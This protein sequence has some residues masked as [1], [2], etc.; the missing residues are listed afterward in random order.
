MSSVDVIIPCY[1]YGHFLT[2]CVESV[3]TQTSVRVQVLIIDDASPDNSAEVAEDLHRRFSNVAFVRHA[4]N[5]GHIATYNEGI[6][7]ASGDYLMI[8]SADDYLLPG[9]LRYSV[10]LMDTHAEVGMTYGRAITLGDNKAGV[11][12]KID[13]GRPVWRVVSGAKFMRLSGA[14]NI[15]PTPTAVVRTSLQ[16]EVGG[17][18]PELP[19]SGDMELWLRLAARS[20]I[21][22]IDVYQ[23]VYR[24]H[25]SN[26]SLAY[27]Q[28]GWLPD[29]EQ[30]Q[31]ALQSF[32]RCCGALPHV[33]SLRTDMIRS[34]ALEALSLASSAFNTG[35]TDIAERI[36]RFATST[37][38]RVRCSITWGKLRCK[39]WMGYQAW[40][41]LQ[42]IISGLPD[43]HRTAQ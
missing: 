14:R 15:V 9:A 37:D 16:K 23:A 39:Q 20:S 38:P 33:R 34:L 1:R 26:M 7:W 32:F 35:E 22:I 3:L 31:A 42:S 2:E 10:E 41:L 4:I 29:L 30:R 43:G 25:T 17:Y 13:N 18:R 6:E 40:Q 21:G 11:E 24:R 36:C 8:L 19:H 5:R 27:R 28:Q 12:S